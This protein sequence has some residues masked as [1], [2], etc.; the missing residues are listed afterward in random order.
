MGNMVPTF[1]LKTNFTL[2]STLFLSYTSSN[3]TIRII[4]WSN[5]SEESRGCRAFSMSHN[6]FMHDIFTI[7]KIKTLSTWQLMH[8]KIEVFI[9]YFSWLTR[10]R[11][12]SCQLH[13]F[14]YLSGHILFQILNPNM[15]SFFTTNAKWHGNL[16]WTI[17][18]KNYKIWLKPSDFHQIKL[19]W[20]ISSY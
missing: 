17:P 9:K 5:F 18:S 11:L 13:D 12:Q 1:K 6:H 2:T 4:P 8:L 15:K 14:G 3:D 7:L 20:L 16:A 19:S 10:P